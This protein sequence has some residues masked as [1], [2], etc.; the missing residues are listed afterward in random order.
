MVRL[1]RKIHKLSNPKY[2][3]LSNFNNITG[4]Y[5]ELF[6]LL[7]NNWLNAKFVP[8]FSNITIMWRTTTIKNNNFIPLNSSIKEL[9][10]KILIINKQNK[11]YRQLVAE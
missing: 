5:K 9:I 8:N 4:V 1:T 6:E 2:L 10:T 11:V 7:F 3:E